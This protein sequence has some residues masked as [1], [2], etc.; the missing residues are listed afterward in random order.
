MRIRLT[1]PQKEGKRLKEK[2]LASA[3][4]VEVDEWTSDEWE[5]V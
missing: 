4:Q 3:E 1:M 5:A 2:V